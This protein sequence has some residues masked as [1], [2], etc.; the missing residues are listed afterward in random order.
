MA[1]TEKA[2]RQIVATEDAVSIPPALQ[3]A[4]SNPAGINSSTTIQRELRGVSNVGLDDD[5]TEQPQPSHPS[6]AKEACFD[7]VHDPGRAEGCCRVP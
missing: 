2:T 5:P 6:T 3:I 1:E 7:G 4:G